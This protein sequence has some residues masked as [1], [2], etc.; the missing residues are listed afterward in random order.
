MTN[1]SRLSTPGQAQR[2]DQTLSRNMKLLAHHELAGFGG[3][4]EG[5]AMQLAKDG[6]R[7]LWMAHESAPK[8]FTAVDVSDPRAPLF[9]FKKRALVHFAADPNEVYMT[10][11][12]ARENTFFLPFNQGSHP[13]QIVCGA[14]N[15]QHASGYRTGY[16]WQETLQRDSFLVAQASVQSAGEMPRSQIAPATHAAPSQ[17]EVQ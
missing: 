17:S 2:A 13:G 8:N 3:M 11:R 9:Q 6:R 12:L 16:F 7:I 14:G 4:G 5:M 15:P 10:T 1:S